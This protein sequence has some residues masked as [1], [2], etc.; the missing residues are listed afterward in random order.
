MRRR[1]I[2]YVFRFASFPFSQFDIFTHI[3]QEVRKEAVRHVIQ[4][5]KLAEISSFGGFDSILLCGMRMQLHSNK[6]L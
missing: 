3:Q 6:M 2:L 5:T 4:D 1:F